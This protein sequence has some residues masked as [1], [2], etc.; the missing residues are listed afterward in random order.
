MI[1][2]NRCT[3]FIPS[4]VTLFLYLQIWRIVA[5][6][7]TIKWVY[8]F[9]FFWLVVVKVVAVAVGGQKENKDDQNSQK[10]N[11]NGNKCGM[12]LAVRPFPGVCPD[13]LELGGESHG[14]CHDYDGGSSIV[15][16]IY[17]SSSTYC[18]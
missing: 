17:S 7:H 6:E 12:D 8:S 5:H 9:R 16:Y 4:T 10:G 11:Q 13:P 18:C 14:D 3:L 2:C 15:V 1:L